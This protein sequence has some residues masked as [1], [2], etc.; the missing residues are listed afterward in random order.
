MD[1][2][3]ALREAVACLARGEVIAFPTETFYGLAADALSGEAVSRLVALKGRPA[4]KA[5]PCIVGDQAQ[6]PLL[7]AEWP[8]WAQ[9]L[10][11]RFWPGPLTLVVPAHAE[12]PGPLRPEGT[13]GLRLSSH[14]LARALALGLGRPITSTSANFSGGPEVARAADLAPGLRAQLAFVLDGG[15][16]PGGRGS[17]VVRFDAGRLRCL[18]DGAIPFGDVERELR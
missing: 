1:D 15:P 13:V 4:G 16:T 17:T 11:E 14:P 7:C 2:S 5:I 6:V 18:R 10:A 12:L 3:R 9:R 8:A